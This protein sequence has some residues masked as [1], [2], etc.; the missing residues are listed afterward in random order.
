M[1]NLDD[2]EFLPVNG[3]LTDHL[4]LDYLKYPKTGKRSICC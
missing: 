4:T 3:L 1:K 2:F